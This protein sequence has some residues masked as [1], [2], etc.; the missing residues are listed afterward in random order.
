MVEDPNI[1]KSL[2]EQVELLG[3]GHITRHIFIC[4]DQ[5]KP[6]CSTKEDSNESWEYLK[7]RLVEEDLLP[8]P[9]TNG[10]N[11]VFR[12]KANCLKVCEH[13][14]IAVVYP[15]GAWY[16]SV[17]PAVVERIIQEHL[18]GGQPVAEFVIA[19]DKLGTGL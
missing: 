15:D 14:P 8:S 11:C 19:T 9:K 10:R 6:K 16:H 2:A 18:K 5:T 4:A 1:E 3:I 17:T 13:G 7:R 12:T